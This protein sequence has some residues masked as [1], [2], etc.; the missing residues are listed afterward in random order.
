MP[1][2]YESDGMA[3]WNVAIKE[4][5]LFRTEVADEIEASFQAAVKFTEEP[6]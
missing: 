4:K 6:L 1:E 5:P 3:T 2:Q